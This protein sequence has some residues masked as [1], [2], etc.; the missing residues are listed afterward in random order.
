MGV[1]VSGGARCYS[2]SAFRELVQ[3]LCPESW[4]KVLDATF[5]CVGVRFGRGLALR[6][7]G[8]FWGICWLFGGTLWACGSLGVGIVAF[9]WWLGQLWACGGCCLL[10]ES[11]GD[12]LF[13]LVFC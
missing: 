2:R 5:C 9:L 12:V 7:F 1:G 13:K 10:A 4:A 8:G 11:G 3:S 6:G